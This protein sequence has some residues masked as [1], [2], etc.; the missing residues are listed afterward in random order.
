MKNKSNMRFLTM[1]IGCFLLFIS[2]ST[3][4]AQAKE[5]ISV[6]KLI[7]YPNMTKELKIQDPT[8][9]V[10]WRSSNGKIVTIAGTKGAENR[11][12]VL[13]TKKK[14]G[15]CTVTAKVGNKTY[16]YKVTVKKDTKVSRA[17]LVSVKKTDK[18]INVKVRFSNRTND[19]MGYGYSFT[20]E[21]LENGRWKKMKPANN[22][23]FIL[24][25]IMIPEKGSTTET[26][27]IA[28]NGKYTLYA[29]EDF[30]KGVYRL[31][32]SSD[33]KKKAYRCVIFTI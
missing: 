32:T 29:T 25:M 11:T 33:Y 6:R 13:R 30:T 9:E 27:T 10:K 22:I 4:K 5:G 28:S 18:E 8:E 14:T 2:L 23:A 19:E 3:L 31:V 1:F 7:L 15:T 12:A 20:V 16:K 24:P 21:R 17:T 26:Y